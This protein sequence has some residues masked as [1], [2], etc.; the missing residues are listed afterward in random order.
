MF[1][2]RFEMDGHVL[3]FVA[4]LTFLTNLLAGLWP[5]LQ[6]T[7]GDVNELLK[8]QSLGS[9][10]VRLGGVPAVSGHFPSGALRLD[11]RRSGCS[12]PE[13]P[14]A[15]RHAFAFRP[16]DGDDAKRGISGSG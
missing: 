12:D 10:G 2:W 14:A 15:Q 7:K 11:P 1:W 16:D 4:C 13:Y 5:A 8:D 6:A 3:L 9:S